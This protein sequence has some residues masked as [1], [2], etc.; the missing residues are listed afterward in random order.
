MVPWY[1]QSGRQSVSGVDRNADLGNIRMAFA[2]NLCQAAW[3]SEAL[4]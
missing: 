4:F 2:Q 3:K 1:V